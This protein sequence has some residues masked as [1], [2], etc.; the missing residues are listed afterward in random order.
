M[1]CLV[2]FDL[3]I[4]ESRKTLQITNFLARE[5]ITWSLGPPMH[6]HNTYSIHVKFKMFRRSPIFH[7]LNLRIILKN[8]FSRLKGFII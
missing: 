7:K 5:G 4:L 2:L 8:Y 6:R 3:S 1:T